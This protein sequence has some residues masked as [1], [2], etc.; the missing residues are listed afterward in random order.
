MSDALNLSF[1]GCAVRVASGEG[2]DA[3][4]CVVPWEQR[5]EVIKG[6]NSKKGELPFL[7]AYWCLLS[8]DGNTSSLR[9]PHLLSIKLGSEECPDDGKAFWVAP[10]RD[11]GG[12]VTA[13]LMYIRKGGVHPFP[14]SRLS[15]ALSVTYALTARACPF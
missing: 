3:N 2:Q 9:S 11:I 1:D 15:A 13:T 8:D 10:V 14:P 6:M 7:I 12:R 5:A 4:V